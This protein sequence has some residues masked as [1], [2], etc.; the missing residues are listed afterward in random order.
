MM[1]ITQEEEGGDFGNSP[2]SG[3]V[4][5]GCTGSTSGSIVL[6]SGSAI[7][8]TVS[9]FSAWTVHQ[10]KHSMEEVSH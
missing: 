6:G 9:D 1:K 4:G 7:C 3:I 10:P 8:V 2:F 5:D